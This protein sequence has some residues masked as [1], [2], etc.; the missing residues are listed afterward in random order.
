MAN[1][2]R[3]RTVVLTGVTRGL[4]RALVTQFIE[5]GHSVLGCGRSEEAL[6]ELRRAYG[7][8]HD[9][10]A[11]DVARPEQVEAWAKGLLR[12]HGSPDF[13]INNAAIINE[14]APLWKVP[15]DEFDRVID[16]NIKG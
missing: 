15:A 16:V 12:A 5:L 2:A 8:P 11:V 7:P 14:N 1:S 10:A 9:F 13:L 4:G 6:A 3:G